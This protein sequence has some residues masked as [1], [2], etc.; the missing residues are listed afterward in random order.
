[1][2]HWW[3]RLRRT[4]AVTLMDRAAREYVAHHDAIYAAAL[5]YRA[6]LALFPFLLCLVAL[7]GLALRDPAVGER[8]LAAL[9]AQ[10]P[11]AAGL[12]EQVRQVAAVGPARSG[13]LG[14]LGL[15]G[16]A[17]TAS[18]AV[19]TLREALNHAFDVPQ[20]RPFLRG[21]LR[22]LLGLAAVA[23]LGLLSVAA[24]AAL[25]LLRALAV[26][27][28]A[29]PLVGAAWAAIAVALPLPLSWLVVLGIYRFLPHHTLGWR[30]LRGGALV[31]AVGLE[32]ARGGFGLYLAGAGGYQA[33]YGALGGV[34]AFLVFVYLAAGI[35]LF[36][37]ELAAEGAKDRPRGP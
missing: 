19:G 2:R 32:L 21:R 33:L 3:G 9:L 17:W 25:G 29:D 27:W 22:D 15:A 31:A 35:V 16:A 24:T 6:L 23:A 13:L 37:A 10:V 14:L 26:R 11:A 18:G 36:G 12:R 28:V 30:E 1:M 4:T 20:A 5:A 7:A 34:V 8:A